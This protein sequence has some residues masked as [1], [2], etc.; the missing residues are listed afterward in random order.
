MVRQWLTLF[1]MFLLFQLNNVSHGAGPIHKNIVKLDSAA[2]KTTGIEVK[3]LEF[4]TLKTLVEAPGEVIPNTQLTTK[5]S[6]LATGKVVKQYVKQG[7][8]VFEGQPLLEIKSVDTKILDE[9]V[10]ASKEWE[11]VTSLS[12]D[13]V[14]VKRYL[15]AKTSYQQAYNQA[16]TYGMTEATIKTLLNQARPIQLTGL[17][18]LSA[19]QSGIVSNINFNNGEVVEAGRVLLQIVGESAVWIEAK[20]P[21]ELFSN[22][23]T[24]DSVYIVVQG[25]S[26]AGRVIQIHHQLDKTIRTRSIRIEVTNPLELLHPGQFVT[27]EIETSLTGPVL[28][29]PVGEIFETADN[30]SIIYVEKQPGVFQQVEIKVQE[31]IGENAIIAGVAAG[32]RI[33]VKGSFY[34]HSKLSKSSFNFN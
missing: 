16:L 23:R 32:T 21:P 6:S 13:A 10:L 19:T 2:L 15:A 14:S 8:H 33:V 4:Q 26:M 3:S 1:M 7:E 11:K 18:I 24:G 20:L 30:S 28:A 27:C 22:I 34:L 5:V 29:V 31:V 25:R 12:K 9:L 17:Y